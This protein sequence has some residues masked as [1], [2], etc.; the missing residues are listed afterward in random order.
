MSTRVLRPKQFISHWIWHHIRR[1]TALPWFKGQLQ[2]WPKAIH[3]L[4]CWRVRGVFKPRKKYKTYRWYL[5]TH[6]KNKGTQ[7]LIAK[8][9]KWNKMPSVPP[10]KLDPRPR[11]SSSLQT[12][13][14]YFCQNSTTRSQPHTLQTISWPLLTFLWLRCRNGNPSIPTL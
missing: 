13:T 2:L 10:V 12:L 5:H 6:K 14:E 3:C 4:S 1:R 11:L 8:D 9:L 7:H